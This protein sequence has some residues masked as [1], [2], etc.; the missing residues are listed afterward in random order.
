M[1]ES[2]AID[3]LREASVSAVARGLNVTWDELD[4]LW[5]RAVRRGLERRQETRITRF[6][7][8]ETSFQ[9]RHEYVTVVCD[10]E[11]RRVLYVADGRGSDA[12]ASF[13]EGMRE[14]QR[15]AIEAVAMDM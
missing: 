3:W 13:Y 6:G 4:G 5:S 12:L 15:E 8:D 9:R 2:L 11:G 10:L 14:G 7:V 1:F